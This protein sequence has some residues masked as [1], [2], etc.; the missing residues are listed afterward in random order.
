M[1][2]RMQNAQ[3]SIYIEPLAHRTEGSDVN[4]GTRP[5]T[6]NTTKKVWRSV[7]STNDNRSEGRFSYHHRVQETGQWI[8]C[9]RDGA[10]Q[11]R[12]PRRSKGCW[13]WLLDLRLIRD[14]QS[15]LTGQAEEGKQEYVK[16]QTSWSLWLP[17]SNTLK[18][19]A[20]E[21]EHIKLI[22]ARA[23][24]HIHIWRDSPK[25]IEGA[26]IPKREHCPQESQACNQQDLQ[27]SQGEFKTLFCYIPPTCQ[28]VFG[29]RAMA[30]LCDAHSPIRNC[31]FLAS[32]LSVI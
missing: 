15:S 8:T 25:V 21:Q 17:Y 16:G 5:M 3:E 27:P 20:R 6:M 32:D 13:C 28:P 9:H 14:S 23:A 29:H 1:I 22:T 7:K 2:P 19:R 10:K 12:L 26:Y 31:P 24:G 11:I 18:S 4:A 30:H